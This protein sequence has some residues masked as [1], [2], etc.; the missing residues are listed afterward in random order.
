MTVETLVLIV[1]EVDCSVLDEVASTTVLVNSCSRAEAWRSNIGQ[2]AVRFSLND[3]VP[4]L[5]TGTKLIPVNIIA[6]N[7][8][9]VKRDVC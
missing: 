5:V 9:L 7:P 1:G 3:N 8:K 4:A 2:R 6:I